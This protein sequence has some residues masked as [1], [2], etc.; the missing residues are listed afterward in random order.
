[1]R[2]MYLKLTESCNLKCPFCYINQKDNEMTLDIALEN[3]DKYNPEEIIFH[4]G[5]PLLKKKLI[6]SILKERPDKKYSIT[7]NLTADI[8][9]D[10]KYILRKCSIATSYSYDRFLDKELYKKFKSNFKKALKLNNITLLITLTREQ[11]TRPIE[12]LGNI[13]KELNP[14]NVT[15]ERVRIDNITDK[16]EYES[17]YEDIDNY[18][19]DIFSNNIIPIEKN[20][21]YWMMKRS[22]ENNFP[23]YNKCDVITINPDGSSLRCPNGNLK[24]HKLRECITCDLYQ[25]C[26]QDCPS[27]SSIACSFPKKTFSY[28]Y[29]LNRKVE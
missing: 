6:L 21:L 29:N 20:N 28:I 26:K 1:M 17:L 7:T 2:S 9:K 5:E 25:Y 23:V 10:I 16:E 14:T 24:K 22:I 3:I 19:F 27:F 8:D 15:L 13:I 4:G 18:L 12:E 11:L